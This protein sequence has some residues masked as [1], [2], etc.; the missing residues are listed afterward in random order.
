MSFI[1]LLFQVFLSALLF[2]SSFVSVYINL[3]KKQFDFLSLFFSFS[4]CSLCLLLFYHVYQNIKQE[5][6]KKDTTKINKNITPLPSYFLAVC[7]ISLLI[8]FFNVHSQ[9]PRD[10]TQP[11]SYQFRDSN[12]FNTINTSYIQQQPPLDYYFSALSGQLFHASKFSVRFHTMLFYLLLCLILPLGLYYYSSL[13]VSSLGSLLF[14]IN[15]ITKLHAV[16][17]RPLNLA[18]LTGFFFL[19]F[20][21]NFFHSKQ[22]QSLTPIIC[23]QYLFILSIGLQPVIF[24]ITLFLSSFLPLFYSKKEIFKKLFLSHIITAILSSPFYFKI[25]AFGNEASKFK[26]ISLSSIGHYFSKWNIFHFVQKYF[27]TFYDKISLSF[28]LPLLG[29]ILLVMLKKQKPDKKTLLLLSSVILFPLLFD[30]LFS[31]GIWYHNNNW[32]FI[33]FSL[34]LIF[35][36]IFICQ[37]LDSYLK[38]KKYYLYILIPFLILFSGNIYLQTLKI[39]KETKSLVHDVNSIEKVYDYLKENGSSEDFCLEI[40]L[41]P[42]LNGYSL[43]ISTQQ[44][45][46]YDSKSTPTIV[47][48]WIQ[49][50]KEPPFFSESVSLQIYYINW[51]TEKSYKKSQKVFFISHRKAK[52]EDISEQILSQLLPKKLIGQFAVFELTLSN[53]NKEQEYIHFLHKIKDKTPKKYQISLLETLIYYSYKKKDKTEFNKLLQEYKEL[54]SY[55]PKYSSSFKYPIH[56]D[57]QRRIKFFESLNWN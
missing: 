16:D 51:N 44:I 42:P 49:Y 32:Y 11:E 45:F 46:F 9:Y 48:K 5:L 28:F 12:Q 8:G 23:S 18:L 57:H 37:S 17:A 30:A 26:E 54:K 19:F 22:K 41:R 47:L 56:F 36:F 4:L 33:T 55:L 25:L 10:L 27:F 29:W 34:F 53:T 1:P 35:F 6:S 15:H 20:Y 2:Y 39:K 52:M 31:I 38:H 3:T 21:I 14:L 24:V 43:N 50:T 40:S 13:L 7:F